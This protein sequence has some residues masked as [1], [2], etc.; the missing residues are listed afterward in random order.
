[1]EKVTRRGFLAVAGTGAVF[2]AALH[3]FEWGFV[4][5]APLALIGAI[6]GA[7]LTRRRN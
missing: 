5:F 3:V 7:V 6:V 1:M 2:G 4:R